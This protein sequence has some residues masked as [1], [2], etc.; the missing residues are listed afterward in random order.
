MRTIEKAALATS[1]PGV[2][3]THCPDC[4]GA[5]YRDAGE[6]GIPWMKGFQRRDEELE[7]KWRPALILACSACEFAE[8][9]RES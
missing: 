8:E 1:A 4:G 9:I 6:I 3:K 5:L 2:L 7:I